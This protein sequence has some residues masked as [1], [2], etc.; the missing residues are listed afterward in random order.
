MKKNFN[1]T[2]TCYPHLHYM[3]DITEKKKRVLE[4]VER[5]EYFVINRPRQYGK[6]TMLHLIAD[7]LNEKE[8]YLPITLNF[9]GID[10]QWHQSDKAFAQMFFGQLKRYFKFTLPNI[11]TFLAKIELTVKDM[12]TLSDA[13]SALMNHLPKK[14]V[15]LIDEV[16]ASSNFDPFLSFLGM[17][18]TKFL[19]RFSRQHA[20]FHSIVL[21]GVHDIKSLK[22]KINPNDSSQYNSPWNIATDFEV[23]MEFNPAEI[24][25][26]LQEYA[27]AENVKMDSSVIADKL[28]YFTAGYPFLVTRLCKIIAEK[29]L[30][31]KAEKTW[32][33]AD[34]EHAVQ[35]LLKESNTNFDS[36]IKNLE[37]NPALY[38]LVYRTIIDGE[39]IP[40][41]PD[42]PLINLGRMY[43]LFKA[44]GRLKIHNRIY[45]QRIYNYMTVKSLVGG[46][47]LPNYAGH[48]LLDQNEL[49]MKAVLLKFQQVMKEQYSDKQAH[50]LEE[51]GRLI[52]L[53]FL[54]PILNGQGYSFKEVQ[55]SQE[56]RLDVIVTY[57]QHRYIL[58]LK[59]WY[60]QK[61]H[62]NGLD[63]L[64][65]YLSIHSLSTGFL[66]IFDSRKKKTW[67]QQTIAHRGKT[68]FA[69][70][71]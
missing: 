10:E 41:N 16:D 37:N 1:V 19:A 63:Q 8:T 34:I 57:F 40:F 53:A 25:P 70:W 36:L 29:I 68:I 35:L 46:H 67:Q 55:V 13:I 5:G 22:Y 11:S 65:D 18:R 2:G 62:K 60:G 44:N 26:M 7:A 49:N 69:V 3:M 43:G 12:E 33:L 64:A 14:I 6:T 28:Y 39:A 30:P 42:E 45:E 9:Q 50:F 15:L 71:V 21:A 54:A 61:A 27:L 4:M 52:F 47:R 48:F 17:L 24:R 58:E 20:T 23:R 32:S 59:Q 56:K 66:L 31:S 38:Q 51:Q